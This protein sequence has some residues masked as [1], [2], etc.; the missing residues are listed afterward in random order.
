MVSFSLIQLWDTLSSFWLDMLY[1][2]LFELLGNGAVPHV[3]QSYDILEGFTSL[4]C[5]LLSFLLFNLS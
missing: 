1:Y 4:S 5:T 3:V 2:S